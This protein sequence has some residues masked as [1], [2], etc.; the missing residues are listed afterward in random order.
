MALD[1]AGA[2]LDF[3]LVRVLLV[4]YG[5]PSASP[6]QESISLRSLESLPVEE[7]LNTKIVM[8]TSIAVQALNDGMIC[9][10]YYPATF[11][12]Y[13]NQYPNN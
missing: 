9:F 3:A 6:E 11:S 12:L 5:F 10:K 8:T 4:H 2:F 13:H 1:G 7:L